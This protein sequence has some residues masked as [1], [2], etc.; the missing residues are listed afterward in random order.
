M[1][2]MAKELP[3]QELLNTIT[4]I[5]KAASDINTLPALATLLTE[6]IKNKFG[7]FTVNL[8][9]LDNADDD[10]VL[11]GLMY[12][13][14][15]TGNNSEEV[16][17]PLNSSPSLSWITRNHQARVFDYLHSEMAFEQEH[18]AG[19]KAGAGFPFVVQ[20]EL[21]AILF[22]YTNRE[23]G[24]P[25]SLISALELFSSIFSAI[26]DNTEKAERFQGSKET[27]S[28]LK[29]LSQD[30]LLAKNDTEV[31]NYLLT[32][33]ASSDFLTGIYSVEKDHLSV[34]GIN[35]PSAPRAR[36]SFEGIALPLHDIAEKLPQDDVLFIEDL[37]ENLL[38]RNLASFYSRNEYQSAAMF[39]IYEL[40][41]LS[42]IIVISSQ[43]PYILTREDISKY[44]GLIKSTRRSLS[45]FK[46]IKHLNQQLDELTT[47]QKVSA[48]VTS[49]TNLDSLYKVLHMQIMDAIGS[50]VSFLVATIDDQ[51]KMVQ[52]PYNFT[53]GKK[54]IVDPFPLG[55][56]ITSLLF[57]NKK[58][59]MVNRN[60]RLKFDEMG[61]KYLGEPS[62]SF[63]GIPL[64]VEN[65]AVG[66]IIVQDMLRENRFSENDLNLLST[67][68]PHV[69]LALRNVQTFTRMQNAINALDQESYLLNSL[70]ANIPELVYF[71][72]PQ[73]KYTRVSQSY[74]DLIGMSN[75]TLLVGQPVREFLST[76]GSLPNPSLDFQALE[77][78]EAIIDLVDQQTDAWG[79]PHWSLNSR[80]PL[81]D[82][83]QNLS[84]LLGLTQNINSFKE[85]EQLAQ[86]RAQRLEIASEIASEAST[87]LEVDD[88]LNKAV[89]LV[90]DRFGYYHA[91][92]F[93][94]DPLGEYAVLRDAA[95][96]IGAEMI[97]IGH[98]LAVGSKSLVGQATGQGIPVIIEDVTQDPNYYPN[99]LL[100]D[101]RAE[102]VVPVKLGNR[103]IGALD[104]QSKEVNAFSPEVVDI[105]QILSD[106]L[107]IATS[108]AQLFSSTQENLNKTRSLNEVST[109]ASSSAS[110]EDALRLAASGLQSVLNNADI[111]IFLMNAKQQLELRAAAGF[112]TVNFT[113]EEFTRED[114]ILMKSLASLEPVLLRSGKSTETISHKTQSAMLIPFRFATE[115]MGILC[116]ESEEIAVFDQNDFE[117][118]VNFGNMLASIIYNNS[119]LMQV[120]RQAE[121]QQALFDITN[122]VRQSVEMES[123]LQTSVAEICKA[124]GAQR[125]RIEISPLQESSTEVQAIVANSKEIQ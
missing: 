45:Q 28:T 90:R 81:V 57:K 6:S 25:L 64:L 118:M 43:S 10:E 78:K 39:T 65:E 1:P 108:N 107:A 75:P 83:D 60:A 30:I 63:L 74:A 42:K 71:L 88:I 29:Q 31:I 70:L 37:S 24:I 123:I 99:P 41:Q 109:R 5:A 46:E 20:S 47:F 91:S 55:E 95:G 66:A 94:I 124:V 14:D 61:A 44:D 84:G 50:D 53:D 58:P 69:A 100:P 77:S 120:R 52:I 113:G 8:L 40:G 89:N 87:T 106:Q 92:Y 76:E 102:M 67:L 86:D 21:K 18:L 119:L 13:S 33:L 103:I 72:D 114:G 104:V 35:D 2:N 23:E 51:E 17:F 56:G 122:K 15:P 7:F 22:V 34:L 59:I 82:Q 112:E 80:I 98:K 125:A 19:A 101:T 26:L 110:T 73:G 121:R 115:P 93:Q 116:V 3:P 85:T 111:A 62:K 32:G 11:D 4:E 12:S 9:L 27:T 97:K 38:F 68:A 36:S 105:M 96:E 117:L 79:K 16:Q 48:A 54:E 49:E